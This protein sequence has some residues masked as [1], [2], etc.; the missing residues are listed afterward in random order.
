MID[1]I[2]VIHG[3]NRKSTCGARR[4]RQRQFADAY[5]LFVNRVSNESDFLVPFSSSPPSCFVEA[6]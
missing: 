2:G 6:E 3:V 1:S 5:C 4:M